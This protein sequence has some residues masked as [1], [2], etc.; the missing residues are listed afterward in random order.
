VKG[1]TYPSWITSVAFAASDPTGNT[2]AY[3]HE[4]G[5]LRL[6]TNG[7]K[8]WLDLDVSNA[9]PDRYVTELAFDP[10]DGNGLYLTLSGFN[11]STPGQSGHLFRTTNALSG[12]AKWLDISPAVNLPHDCIAIDPSDTKRVWVG[13][14]VGLWESQDGGASW[15]HHGPE[16]GMPNVPVFDIQL[17]PNT[18]RTMAF[19][20]GRGAGPPEHDSPRRHQLL[21]T[22]AQR[23]RGEARSSNHQSC[24]T[25]P[26]VERDGCADRSAVPACPTTAGSGSLRRNRSA[27]L[28][29]AAKREL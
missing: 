22:E 18:G 17:N 26:G 15:T 21:Y 5:E 12:S 11:E 16:R 10:N 27:H 20:H 3:S 7:G 24:L 14:D 25:V 28:E 19:T 1:A 13:T 2:Y 4:S 23:F 29:R 9:V 8:N 6:T